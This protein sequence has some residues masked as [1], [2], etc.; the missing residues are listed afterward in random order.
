MTPYRDDVQAAIVRHYAS[1]GLECVAE[2]HLGLQDNF[3]FSEVTADTLRA[4]VRE[5][6]A[7][8]PDAISILCTNLRGAPLVEELEAELGIPIYDSISTVVWKSLR[9]AGVDTARVKG[10]GHLFKALA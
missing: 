8:R 7:S 9:L 5:V 3:A 10:W 6:A 4:L 2:R 1:A